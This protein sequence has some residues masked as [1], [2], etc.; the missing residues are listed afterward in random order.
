MRVVFVSSF[1][2]YLLLLGLGGR[3]IEI[4]I[5]LMLFS[6]VSN[7]Y[8][9]VFFCNLTADCFPQFSF[10]QFTKFLLDFFS[11]DVLWDG[12]FLLH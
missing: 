10:V 11:L 4:K 1:F 5:I 6:Q 3:A 12:S 7:Y 9:W 2:V 8:F